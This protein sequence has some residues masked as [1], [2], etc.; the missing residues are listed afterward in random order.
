MRSSLSIV[1]DMLAVLKAV[2]EKKN[3]AI[4]KLLFWLTHIREERKSSRDK[5]RYFLVSELSHRWI[6]QLIDDGR[7]PH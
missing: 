6:E 5:S 7:F 1:E 3:V 4:K 2:D